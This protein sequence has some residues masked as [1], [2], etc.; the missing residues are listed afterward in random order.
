M[1]KNYHNI[2]ISELSEAELKALMQELAFDIELYNKAYHQD[3]APLISDADYDYLFNFYESLEKRFPHLAPADSPTLKVGSPVL[4]KF[5]KH[6]HTVPMLSLSNVFTEED[7]TDFIEG[8]QR[9]LMTEDFPPIFCEPKIDGLSFTAIYEKGILKVASTRGDGFEG[10]DIT[11]NIKT[12]KNFPIK[13]NNAPDFLEVR[14]EVYI[15]KADF[16]KLNQSQEQA[17]KPCFA[18]PRNAAAGSLRQLDSS[19]TASRPLKYFVYASTEAS[20]GTIKTQEQL[21][22]ELE[23]FGFAVN[24]LRAL[25]ASK[26]AMLAFYEKLKSS[27]DSLPY[28][29][30]GVVYKV[31]SFELQNRLGF[32][33]RSPR[34]ATAHKF[35]AIIGSTRLLGITVQVGRTG[36]LTPVA[37]LE[38]IN[39]AGVVVS[40]ASLHNHQ[41]ILRKDLRIGDYVY[42]QRAGDV[43]PQIIGVDFKR[44]SDVA[45]FT[46]PARCPSCS[47]LLHYHE[48][49]LIVRCDNGLSC[50]A[51]NYERI[52]HFVS[53]NALD[54]DG[55]GKKQ[56]EFLIKQG[57]IKNPV[58]IFDIQHKNNN[59]LAKLQNMP[60]WGEK[61]VE[62]LFSSIEKARRVSLNRF[63]YSLGIRH[64]GESNAKL[65][66]Q[67]FITAQN[68]TDS[69]EMLAKGDQDI[70]QKLNDL[71]GIGDKILVD[72]IDFFD[73]AE[74]LSI[75]REL[76]NILSID[77]YRNDKISNDILTGKT[78]VFTGTLETLSRAEAK[79][80]AESLGAKVSSSVSGSTNLVIAG[81][82]AGSKLKKATEFGVKV[83]DEAEWKRLVLQAKAK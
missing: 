81:A 67:E 78:V 36:V 8:I 23:K 38:P 62:N 58:D 46:F 52:C 5:A 17:G 6:T 30:D 55:L 73:I 57:M 51:Q 48:D 22:I 74:N 33:A 60:G 45:K 82:D 47:S 13:L 3:D 21:L 37:E 1:K 32:I 53:K 12:I 70:Y 10:E 20:I 66:A 79:L 14:G 42:L 29:I 7:V 56:V 16:E 39:I 68:F 9:F 76:L 49:D 15:E 75:T 50:A 18:N 44:R 41:E 54:I 31:N 40:R 59:S 65:L 27:R 4:E 19:I 11:P 2:N 24:H 28:E 25:G 69:M 61:S 72:V 34:F 83:I 77:D 64:I 63:I 71:D 35:P 26:Q 43:I 80:Q